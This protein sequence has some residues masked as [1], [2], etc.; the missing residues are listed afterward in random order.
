VSPLP[1]RFFLPE[2]AEVLARL[3]SGDADRDWRELTTGDRIW[4]LQT[5]LRLA[6]RR[7][8]VELVGEIP[9]GSPGLLLFHSKHERQVRGQGAAGDQ[10]LVGIRAD[11]RQPLAA[12]FEVLQNGHFTD[13]ERRFFV[14]HWPQPGLIPRDPARGDRIEVASYKGYRANLQEDFLAPA[15]SAWLASRGVAWR[16][17]A[18]DF[19]Q[20]ATEA[21][22]LRWADYR[23]VDLFVA[24]R[25]AERKFRFAKPASKLVNSWL[26]GV[27]ALLGVEHAAREL[28]RDPLDYVEVANAEE[29]RSVVER[30]QSDPGEYRARI[31]HGLRRARD[32]TAEAITDRWQELLFETLP[33]LAERPARRRLRRFPL[34]VRRQARLFR[35]WARL[36]PAR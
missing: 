34:A 15:W 13:D 26:A 31:E 2:P 21:E 1:V 22:T 23:D 4:V 32:F 5:Y 10:V 9:A 27:P 24:V 36:E 17:D 25:P 3:A 29:A 12:E 8:P 20:R 14:P 33:A 16:L 18:I 28:R 6:A 30:L 11:N 7:L 35:R 19:S